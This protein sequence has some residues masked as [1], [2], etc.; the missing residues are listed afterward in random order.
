MP[1]EILE[2]IFDYLPQHML[3]DISLVCSSWQATVHS[4]ADSY[5]T[6]CVKNELID[7]KQ[8]ERWG[9]NTRVSE[10]NHSI[11][12]CSCI[13]LAFGFFTQKKSPS[14]P[15]KR[16]SRSIPGGAS[17]ETFAVRGQKVFVSTLKNGTF[18]IKVL[19]RLEPDKEPGMWILPESY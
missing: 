2:K 1:P 5:L 10:D 19:D 3:E 11:S 16:C 8:L 17:V 7:E 9:W 14:M 15:V 13:H 12:T 6:R 4:L 18:S